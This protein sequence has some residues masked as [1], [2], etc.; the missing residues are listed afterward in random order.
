V[1][2][3]IVY[4]LLSLFDVVGIIL[5]KVQ[6]RVPF[7]VKGDPPSTYYNFRIKPEQLES[8]REYINLPPG[9]PLCEIKC[10]ADESAEYLLTLNVYEVTGIATG[11]RAEWSTYVTDHLGTPRYMVL[12]A[13]TSKPSFD[14]TTLYVGA[15]DVQHFKQD[16]ILTSV[17]E[18]NSGKFFKAHADL[19]K[20]HATKE[21]DVAG[22]W[23]EANDYIYWRNGICDRTFYEAGM[24][25]ARVI[26]LADDAVTIDDQTHWAEFIDLQPKH[27]LIYETPLEFILVPW[28]NL[29]K[30]E[31]P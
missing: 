10:L 20:L 18:S 9:L 28:R 30:I 21:N 8:F 5:G 12:E 16:Q 15:T 24:A 23:I 14:A 22:E 3:R 27:S 31:S 26:R 17:V 7:M 11:F 13:R 4:P 29:E 1:F 6:P 19:S 2:K 25:N